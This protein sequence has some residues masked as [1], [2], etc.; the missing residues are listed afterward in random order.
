MALL[1]DSTIS[2]T[3]NR[4]SSGRSSNSSSSSLRTSSSL[5]S[6]SRFGDN[7][8]PEVAPN[9]NEE[10]TFSVLTFVFVPDPPGTNYTN[11]YHKCSNKLDLFRYQKIIYLE[12]CSRFWNVCS[13][14][15]AEIRT[16]CG[17]P[18]KFI[19]LDLIFSP[20]GDCFC[21]GFF[22]VKNFP[23]PD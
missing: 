22:P 15:V 14:K 4:I 17:R 9:S 10:E 7:N 13:I 5:R 6:S 16:R 19:R 2:S 3:L 12:K 20:F 23:E 21:S 18:A 1:Y 8:D 11:R